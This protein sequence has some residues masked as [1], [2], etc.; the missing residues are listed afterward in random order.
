MYLLLAM[1]AKKQIPAVPIEIVILVFLA[2]LSSIWSFK[3]ASTLIRGTGLLGATVVGVYVAYRY[4]LREIL[5]MLWCSSVF[6][7]IASIVAI[8]G[9]PEY[10][11]KMDEYSIGTDYE[12]AYRGIFFS[13]NTL[14][15][16]MLLAGITF[17]YC[18]SIFR[19]RQTPLRYVNYLFLLLAFTMLLAAH[20]VSMY[21][22][23]ATVLF[24]TAFLV[25]VARH[26]MMR[27]P[28]LLLAIWTVGIVMV[29]FFT[30]PEM[31]TTILGREPTLTNRTVI[32]AFAF[33][34]I[35][36]R[37]L[38]G[39]GYGVFWDSV[40]TILGVVN[41]HNGYL[42][43]LLDLGLLG[44]V[45]LLSVLARTVWRCWAVMLSSPASMSTWPAAILLAIVVNNFT[46]ADLF[47][48]NSMQWCLFVIVAAMYERASKYGGF[49]A[50]HATVTM[51]A[52]FAV[53]HG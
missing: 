43:V 10:G 15:A 41:A 36:A 21:V 6:M 4:T 20:S 40:G 17:L 12:A 51:P 34:M 37:P 28:L 14:A 18:V 53:R 35:E 31:I 5:M 1:H 9:F 32:W 46:E 24:G 27:L 39:Y 30:A 45:L 22:T 50:T 47:G 19:E 8:F 26:R 48:P 7:L 29:I 23:T 3:P 25:L 16:V 33:Q 42:T 11:I 13:K 52:R 49:E 2:L 38:L 44:A